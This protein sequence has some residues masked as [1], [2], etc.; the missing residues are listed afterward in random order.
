MPHWLFLASS[1]VSPYGISLRTHVILCIG[2]SAVQTV[3]LG[4]ACYICSC[5]MFQQG[6]QECATQVKAMAKMKREDRANESKGC[7]PPSKKSKKKTPLND[8]DMPPK[9]TEFKGYDL[10]HLP[11]EALPLYG[12]DYKGL[13]SYTV[14][15]NGA[16]SEIDLFGL[17]M[18]WYDSFSRV[19]TSSLSDRAI[20]FPLRLWKCFA[21]N[22]PI[23]SNGPLQ[24]LQCR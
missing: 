5:V 22:R 1:P 20:E 14:N 4:H 21:S 17:W 12:H 2:C 11:L 24:G 9:V 15:I 18:L 6:F 7:E 23:A 10:N 8:D 3:N 16:A 19:S 13:H